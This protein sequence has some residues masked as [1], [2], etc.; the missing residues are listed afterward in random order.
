MGLKTADPIPTPAFFR[1][2][3]Y[4]LSISPTLLGKE[5]RMFLI[6]LSSALTY[7]ICWFGYTFLLH[8]YRD[9]DPLVLYHQS[10]VANTRKEGETAVYRSV[11]TPHGID[12]VTGLRISWKYKLRDGNLKDIWKLGINHNS[13]ITFGQEEYSM[14]SL[15]KT[16]QALS[17][18]IE[19]S[20]FSCI[21]VDLSQYEWFIIILTGLC[22]LR[23]FTLH[24]HED[25]IETYT[26]TE[27]KVI[28]TSFAYLDRV[29]KSDFDTIVLVDSPP[30]PLVIDS[31]VATFSS[32]NLINENAE[33]YEYTFDLKDDTR[34][35]LVQHS[36]GDAFTYNQRC[37]VS[38]ISALLQSLPTEHE[39]STK[40]RLLT[41]FTNDIT[42]N[43]NS[44]VKIF[45]ALVTG[46]NVRILPPQKLISEL[47]NSTILNIPDNLLYQLMPKRN[48]FLVSRSRWLFSKGVF[49][50][51]AELPSFRPLRL[52]YTSILEPPSV[53]SP[54]SSSYNYVQA[55]TGARIINERLYEHI[56]GPIVK[57]NLFDY[58]ITGGFVDRKHTFPRK[59]GVS[60]NN[61]EL[62]LRDYQDYSADQKEGKL[63]V[64]GF[65]VGI[66]DIDE[67]RKDDY[68]T[69]TD[70]VGKFGGD[71]VL[72][73]DIATH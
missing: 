23:D 64:R 67:F 5:T 45:G 9:V 12:L 37:F 36:Q 15:T 14:D 33:E 61:G 73:E 38:S 65:N 20:Q 52:I 50:K 21:G 4:I 19:S 70:I 44:L 59:L 10:S 39:W 17:N 62:I 72:Y 18:Y 29:L 3:I 58:R 71:G 35:L 34:N 28:F 6:L 40:D 43:L 26:S 22:S 47:D 63:S 11:D 48:S 7:V 53:S 55:I 31:R 54:F 51:I 16:M 60:A 66:K 41:T 57:T 46:I 24:F 8:S 25:L 1:T 56:V 69:H 68:W 30:C 42:F 32:L 27:P 49:N 13:K 2:Y